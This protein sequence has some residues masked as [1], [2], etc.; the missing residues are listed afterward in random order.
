MSDT[1]PKK[2]V[3]KEDRKP[4]G[5][6]TQKLAYPPRTGFHRHWFNEEPGRIDAALAAGYTHVEDKEGR[7]VQRIVGVNTAGGPLN[8]YLMEIPEEWYQEDMAEQQRLVDEKDA[9]IRE[10]SVG[11]RPG[12]DGRYV[13]KIEITRGR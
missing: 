11:G 1:L 12:E 8:A 3:S 10:G 6:Q 9:A 4:F 7:K 2:R 13:K 5:S